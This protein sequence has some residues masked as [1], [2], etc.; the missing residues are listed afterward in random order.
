MSM[1]LVKSILEKK[2][3]PCKL[4]MSLR[5]DICYDCENSYVSHEICY[6]KIKCS[7]DNLRLSEFYKKHFHG[8]EPIANIQ[9][10]EDK[11]KVLSMFGKGV[12]RE[13]PHSLEYMMHKQNNEDKESKKDLKSIV[14][15]SIKNI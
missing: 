7:Y 12:P 1:D 9:L 11:T 4:N 15:G 14:K 10:L 5:A 3:S 2:N 6:C 13:C 8:G